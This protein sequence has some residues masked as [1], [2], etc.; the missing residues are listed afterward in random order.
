[1]LVLVP[2][3]RVVE[4]GEELVGQEVVDLDKVGPEDLEH[5]EDYVE[6]VGDVEGGEDVVEAVGAHVLAVQ[7]QDAHGVAQE[8]EAPEHWR[9]RIREVALSLRYLT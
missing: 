5:G 7:H 4:V 3:R 6:A 1:M 2:E 8:A 9:R